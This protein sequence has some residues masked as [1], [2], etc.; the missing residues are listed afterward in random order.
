MQ[1][2]E[3]G[4]AGEIETMQLR[5]GILQQ[6]DRLDADHPA[7]RWRLDFSDAGREQERRG[8]QRNG[9]TD[10]KSRGS[11]AGESRWHTWLRAGGST[12]TRQPQQQECDDGDEQD[13][14]DKRRTTRWPSN[15]C[16]GRSSWLIAQRGKACRSR[17]V[18]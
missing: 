15:G 6:T 9:L 3:T 18:M 14:V 10:T 17:G 8:V 2:K 11:A 7:A 13:D 4:S 1:L 16:I 5:S 12:T